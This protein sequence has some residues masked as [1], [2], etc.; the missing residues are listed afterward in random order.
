MTNHI[1]KF[2]AF[3]AK[4]SSDNLYTLDGAVPFYKAL[5]FGFEH[6]LIMLLCNITPIIVVF[7]HFHDSSL[8]INAIQAGLLLAGISTII[9]I[10]PVWIFG[11][12]LPVVAGVS[13]TFM[14]AMS[15][16]ASNYD[17]GVLMGSLLVGGVFLTLIGFLG[18]YLRK[19][20]KPVVRATVVISVGLGLIE[21]GVKQ[22]FSVDTVESLS[23]TGLYDFS[24]AWPYLV[25]AFISLMAS[26]LFYSYGKGIWKNISVTIGLT[27]GYL[28][29][30]I[31]NYAL[32]SYNILDFSNF[33]FSTFSDFLN[34][35]HL[36]NF[37]E[38]RFDA[39]AII[40]TCIIYLI[41]S[42]EGLGDLTAVSSTNLEREAKDR[43]IV[44]G[45]VTDGLFS[46]ATSLFGSMPLTT[47]SQN[48][49][50]VGKSGIINK[51]AILVG[52]IL[53]IIMGV[54]PCVSIFLETIPEA[55]MG[56]TMLMV[57][58]SILIV[59]FQMFSASGTT[60]KN[61][62]ILSVSI[63][64]GYGVTLLGKGFFNTTTFPGDSDFAMILLQ[65]P[66]AM[67]F[68]LSFILSY[69]IPDSTNNK[70]KKIEPNKEDD[71]SL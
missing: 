6:V 62:A 17:Y 53:L 23:S 30:V 19:V 8:T 55:V 49:G 66:E 1:K 9:E 57:Y 68:L 41:A 35:P 34:F 20:I 33:H 67:M 58:L 7:A 21:E 59:G 69:L 54:I 42:I 39:K 27:V 28:V 48:V 13:F 38:L 56:G 46:I 14:G 18:K 52:A 70:K 47:S 71:N 60:P 32:P 36:V 65:N 51:F 43:E 31:F 10:Y 44:G 24:K 50:Y 2:K 4:R 40:F 11:S 64:L 5:A 26:L 29:S 25:I 45:L 3:Y 37:G 61:V 15:L 16:V 12:G 63:G 22:F